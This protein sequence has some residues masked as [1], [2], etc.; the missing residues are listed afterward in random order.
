[1]A[2]NIFRTEIDRYDARAGSGD[3]RRHVTLKDISSITSPMAKRFLRRGQLATSHVTL[4]ARTRQ[5]AQIMPTPPSAN[6]Q[7]A[8][9]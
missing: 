9:E 1:M 3:K 6:V 4:C 2:E 8:S 7:L 5:S